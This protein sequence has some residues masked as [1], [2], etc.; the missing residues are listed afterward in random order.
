MTA[1]L[2]AKW[3][4]VAA[5]IWWLCCYAVTYLLVPRSFWEGFLVALIIWLFLGWIGPALLL[6]T[7][8]VRRG[9]IVSRVCA[10]LVFIAFVVT[11]VW[12][13]LYYAFFRSMR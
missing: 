11:F 13:T 3:H 10:V 4:G 1:I 2:N 9:P 8:G 6:A 5:L 12:P 7:S